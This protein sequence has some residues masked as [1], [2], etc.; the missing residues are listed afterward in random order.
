MLVVANA[1]AITTTTSKWWIRQHPIQHSRY[2]SIILLLHVLLYYYCLLT[3]PPHSPTCYISTLPHNGTQTSVNTHTQTCTKQSLQYTIIN[4]LGHLFRFLWV[5]LTQPLHVHVCHVWKVQPMQ[6]L[7]VAH[8]RWTYE[9][10]NNT[11]VVNLITWSTPEW[12]CPLSPSFICQLYAPK[13]NK[14]TN[15]Q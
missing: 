9:Y 4:T 15:T 5:C 8:N 1:S 3:C 6:C 10:F 11:Y 2:N 12:A 14:E 7:H 13:N